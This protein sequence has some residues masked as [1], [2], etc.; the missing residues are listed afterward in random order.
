MLI[1]I[2]K[3][4]GR[5]VSGKIVELDSLRRLK[6]KGYLLEVGW[7][8]SYK[9]KDAFDLQGNPLPWISYPA[10]RF[11]ADRV[12]ANMVIFEYGS[13]ISTLW[14]AARV[15][16]VISCEHNKLWYYKVKSKIPDNV[17]I[18]HIELEYCG[19]YSKF[20]SKYNNKFDIIVIDGRDRVNC[21]KNCV[22]ALKSDGIILWD[23]ADR[24]SYE[25]GYQYLGERGFKRIDFIG[26]SPIVVDSKCTSIFYR[27]DN[28]LGL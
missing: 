25:E 10:I 23:D 1:K 18:N 24:K 11:I 12:G 27:K 5:R 19:G 15:R 7:F 6:K 4:I 26:M 21:A 17:S 28:C 3:N 8:E 16:E 9:R 20:I 14:W 13:G 22:N 2:I